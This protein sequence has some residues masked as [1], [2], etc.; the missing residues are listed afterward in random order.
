MVSLDMSPN[1]AE[2]AAALN[3]SI[4]FLYRSRNPQEVVRGLET[5]VFLV[6]HES[7]NNRQTFAAELLKRVIHDRIYPLR[8]G[9]QYP[10]LAQEEIAQVWQL[11]QA[12]NIV[13]PDTT[14]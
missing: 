10:I 8:G 11:A 5:I 1:P 6:T 13:S 14:F 12:Q 3:D 2:S 9:A 7:D 4:K